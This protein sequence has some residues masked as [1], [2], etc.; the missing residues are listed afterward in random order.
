MKLAILLLAVVLVATWALAFRGGT[1]P[2]GDLDALAAT[3]EARLGG[4]MVT[5]LAAADL[6]IAT[7]PGCNMSGATILVAEGRACEVRI[8]DGGMRVRQAE[9]ALDRGAG[10]LVWS[11]AP[12]EGE[13]AEPTTASLPA[14]G[15]FA[16]RTL[17]DGGTVALA[18]APGTGGC[19]FRLRPAG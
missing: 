2:Q 10:E 14:D 17:R 15:S 6:R 8:L 9:I 1:R 13:A 16:L 11:P 18:C 19:A 12:V 4:L 3:V 7:A 5:D